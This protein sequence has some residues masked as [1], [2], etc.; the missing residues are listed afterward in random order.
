MYKYSANLAQWQAVTN[1]SLNLL[2]G[3]Q[4]TNLTGLNFSAAAS[5]TDVASIIS[6]AINANLSTKNLYTVQNT[7]SDLIATGAYQL[8]VQPNVAVTYYSTWDV[9]VFYHTNNYAK[10][11]CARNTTAYSINSTIPVSGTNIGASPFLYFDAGNTPYGGYF[12][13]EYPTFDTTLPST[14]FQ[15][16]IESAD[17]WDAA[18]DVQ[19]K[20]IERLT[21]ED[22]YVRSLKPMC[23]IRMPSSAANGDVIEDRTGFGHSFTYIDQQYLTVSSTNPSYVSASASDIVDAASARVDS[24]AVKFYGNNK[25]SNLSSGI[26]SNG[27]FLH[28]GS[29]NTERTSPILHSADAWTVSFWFKPTAAPI[30]D[31]SV[32][33]YIIACGTNKGIG[34]AVKYKGATFIYDDV[35]GPHFFW[36]DSPGIQGVASVSRSLVLNTDF[37]ADQWYLITVRFNQSGLLW[38]V[39]VND[40][41][42]V[43]TV[44]PSQ[45]T[46]RTYRWSE[47]YFSINAGD[48]NSLTSGSVGRSNHSVGDFYAWTRYLT[49]KEI[50]T[51]YRTVHSRSNKH[52]AL[53]ASF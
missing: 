33:N 7:D 48:T 22:E 36:H 2:L 12:Y 20:Q 18:Q 53:M 30:V 21:V 26:F 35:S 49:D 14:E 38:D 52:S 17:W 24:K 8:P 45:T 11:L 9:F 28:Y 47:T 16:Y 39:M 27:A 4:A 29:L 37:V 19:Q 46:G 51:L 32:K 6:T 50:S 5:L 43:S 13:G 34:A 42:D 3:G 1:G 40:K 23:H 25:S 31:G 44:L 15:D 10:S 41:S